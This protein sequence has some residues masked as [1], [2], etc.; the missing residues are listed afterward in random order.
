MKLSFP[1]YV[2]RCIDE[3]SEELAALPADYRGQR[4]VDGLGIDLAFY[5]TG[6]DIWTE[7]QDSIKNGVI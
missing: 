3:T 1:E 4:D 2:K 5:Q 7:Y 6:L